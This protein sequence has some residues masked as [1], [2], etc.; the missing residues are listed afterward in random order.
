MGIVFLLV[1]EAV[2]HTYADEYN[3]GHDLIDALPYLDGLDAA[4]QRRVDALIAAEQK[5]FVARD[6]LAPLR[7]SGGGADV[8]MTDDENDDVD[9]TGVRFSAFATP[10]LKKEV[11]R[12]ASSNEPLQALRDVDDVLSAA[13]PKASAK[14]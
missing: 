8:S 4:A 1:M 14:L 5:T 6:Y 7:A 9:G 11:K 3:E 10:A 13:P 12:K 2:R